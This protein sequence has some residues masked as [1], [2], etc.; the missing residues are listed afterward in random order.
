MLRHAMILAAG[1]GTRLM[2][3]TSLKPKALVEINGVPLLEVVIS[4]LKRQGITSFTLNIHHF[5]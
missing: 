1:K 4:R 2:P 3:F 5:P